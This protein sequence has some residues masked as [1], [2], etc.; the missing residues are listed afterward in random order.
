MS[1]FLAKNPECAEC[2]YLTRCCGGCMVQ[3]ITDDGDYLTPD[4]RNCYFHKHI[5][6][7]AV[8]EAADAAILAAGL[9]LKMKKH[10]KGSD[11]VS[12]EKR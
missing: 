11:P 4:K 3:D 5:G 12:G 7:A 1:D 8:R 10:D 9:P 6:E 2:E